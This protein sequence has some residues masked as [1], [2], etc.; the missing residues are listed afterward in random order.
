MNYTSFEIQEIS[1]EFRNV[2][3]RLSRTDYSQC[4]ANLKRFMKVIQTNQMI[5]EFINENNTT[6]YDIATILKSRGWL[7]P[8]DISPNINEEISFEY[9]LLTYAIQN[10]DGDFTRLYG[11]HCYTSTKSTVNDEMRKFIEHAIDPL[12]DH[13]GEYL[14]HCYEKAIRTEHKETHTTAGAITANNSTVVVGS[15]IGGNISTQVTI[16]EGEKDNAL[17]LIA[18]IKEALRESGLAENDDILEVLK[19]IEDDLHENKKPKKGFLPALKALCAG[20]TP[21]ISLVTALIKLLDPQK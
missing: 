20:S 16:N 3:R 10:F 18:A 21:I 7:E 12:I 11:T 14:R 6:V 19:Q 4:D 1:S 13:I 17:Q 9:Q 2:A 8:F 15:N 5:S